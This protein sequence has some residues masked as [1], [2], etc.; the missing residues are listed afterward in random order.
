[1]QRLITTIR[2]SVRQGNSGGPA[3]DGQ[4]RVQTTIFASRIGSEASGYGV[5][6]ARV[7]EE[8]GRAAGG[9]VST[10]PCVR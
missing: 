9:P 4:G 6:T 10:G 8:L 1:V 7:R 3:V 2:G 5:P